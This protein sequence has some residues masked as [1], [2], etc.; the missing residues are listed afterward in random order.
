MCYFCGVSVFPWMARSGWSIPQVHSGLLWVMASSHGFKLG[1]NELPWRICSWQD[2][3]RLKAPRRHDQHVWH[4]LHRYIHS[5]HTCGTMAGELTHVMGQVS[6]SLDTVSNIWFRR[7]QPFDIL[8]MGWAV[9]TGFLW[10]NSPWAT[11]WIH[12]QILI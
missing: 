3:M 1:C 12:Q 7:I 4:L 9:F 8:Q 10:Y 6:S 5:L 2:H 11:G